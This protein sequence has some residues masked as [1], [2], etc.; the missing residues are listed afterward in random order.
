[1]DSDVPMKR[2]KACEEEK[3]A[4]S[5]FW[6]R[7]SGFKDGWLNHCKVCKNKKQRERFHSPEFHDKML[8]KQHDRYYR[9]DVHERTLAHQ[10]AYGQSHKE[11]RSLRAKR[12]YQKK[13]EHIRA[14]VK[15]YRQNNLELVKERK[16][17]YYS[18]PEVREK[19]RE[20]HRL[21]REKRQPQRK[22]VYRSQ[23]AYRKDIPNAS[24]IYKITCL[25][26]MK[27]YIGSA[28]NLCKR[29]YEHFRLLSQK[30][31]PNRYLQRAWNKYGEDAFIFEV[32][33]LVLP[34]SLTAREQYWFHKLKPLHPKGFNI[35]TEAGS[36]LGMKHTP[37]TI[38]KLRQL[39]TGRKHTP[40][41]IELC[42]Q[43]VLGRTRSPK[44]REK[45]SQAR[46][47]REEKRKE[48]S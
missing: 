4:T 3:P 25:I 27:I 17:A 39:S 34:I 44:T 18:R 2:C 31:H 26:P 32:L 19:S 33:E 10:R 42:R 37:E 43:A 41:T 20:Y 13:G 45:M 7:N 22:R 1:M 36:Q 11:E 5:E 46:R 29:N 21:Y 16:R 30:K 24:G 48:R 40:E 15:E 6:T 28:I 9:P 8:A 23:L 38:E 12:Y 35:M 47:A 14:R